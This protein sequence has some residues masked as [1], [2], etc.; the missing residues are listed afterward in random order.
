MS[1]SN[2][3]DPNNSDSNE[4]NESSEEERTKYSVCEIEVLNG[5]EWEENTKFDPK[6]IRSICPRDEK[7]QKE[8]QQLLGS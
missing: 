2:I 4:N 1:T 7:Q 3:L 8:L 6:L 5:K